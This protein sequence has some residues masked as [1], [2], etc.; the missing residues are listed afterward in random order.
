MKRRPLRG[1]YLKI[2]YDK[3]GNRLTLLKI[4]GGTLHVRDG[5]GFAVEDE[6]VYE[7]VHEIRRYTGAKYEQVQG[8]FGGGR[9]AL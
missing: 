7:T 6:T 5:F 1:R 9:P 2:R 8:A 3:Q 4:T